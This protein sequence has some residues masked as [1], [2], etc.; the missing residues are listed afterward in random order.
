FT[1][2]KTIAEASA[3]SLREMNPLATVTV[4]DENSFDIRKFST[5]SIDIGFDFAKAKAIAE[6]ARGAGVATFMSFGVGGVGWW[7]ADLVKHRVLE[8]SLGTKTAV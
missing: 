6:S 1:S 8:R 7:T 5:V 4:S 3:V 2:Y